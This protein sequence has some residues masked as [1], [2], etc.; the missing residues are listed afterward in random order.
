MDA[1]TSPDGAL[2]V[3]IAALLAVVGYRLAR[4]ARAADWLAVLAYVGALA[5]VL[6]AERGAAPAAAPPIAFRV[7]GALLLVGGLLVAGAPARAART[8][9][10]AGARPPPPTLAPRERWLVHGGLAL[11][12]MGQLLRA[13]TRPAV[14]AVAAAAA[15]LAATAWLGRR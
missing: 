7:V 12:L 2:R 8:A 15:V 9:A 10:P 1:F 13:P 6:L 4:P 11:V 3:A 5:A 14:A